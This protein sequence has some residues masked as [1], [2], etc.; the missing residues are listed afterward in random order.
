MRTWIHH[1][2]HL[3]SDANDTVRVVDVPS[4]EDTEMTQK[5]KGL[6]DWFDYVSASV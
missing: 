4:T 2:I 1:I 6:S 3:H 5:S